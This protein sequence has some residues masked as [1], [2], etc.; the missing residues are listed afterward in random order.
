MTAIITVQGQ[1]STFHPAERATAHLTVTFDGPKRDVVFQSANQAADDLRKQIVSLHD[2]KNGPITWWSSDR[3][4][5]WGNRP[6]SNEGKQ[7]PFV[8]HANVSFSAKFSDFDALAKF[9]ESV[10]PKPG[11]N[12]GWIEW[13]L[14]EKLKD[15]IT[16]DVRT[17]AVQAAAEK[18]LAYAKAAGF[19]T[20]KA[21][22]IADV[23][24]L[25]NQ[26]SGYDNAM[27]AP[28]GM[29]RM[30]SAKAQSG[31]ELSLKP[32][33]IEITASVDARYEAS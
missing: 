18:A 22:A 2:E 5:V 7:L 30:M 1:F 10:A 27:P 11:L 12:I 16:T 33:D 31:P 29:A 9:I 13:A 24:M 14:T 6:W 3:V 28:I 15:Q 32:E 8:Y 26:T 21:V 19:K 23:G 20:V 4:Q 17:K 25:G